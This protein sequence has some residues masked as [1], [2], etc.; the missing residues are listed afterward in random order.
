MAGAA[1]VTVIETPEFIT[2][3]RRLLDEDERAALVDRLASHP[4]AG[5]LIKG[6]GGIRKLRWAMDGRGK[7]GGARIIYFFHN[8]SVPLF[9]LTA[10]A[11]NVQSDLSGQ[12]RNDF[13]LMTRDLVSAYRRGKK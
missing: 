9:L 13:R 5:E 1:P 4:S 10:Y 8:A 7:R 6:T 2:A 3:V 11:K 12:D